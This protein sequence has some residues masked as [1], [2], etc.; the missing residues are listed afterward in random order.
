MKTETKAE[1]EIIR[2]AMSII[3]SKMT[4]KRMK[5]LREVQAPMM[6]S[7]IKPRKLNRAAVLDIR[8]NCVDYRSACALAA[9]YKVNP[10]TVI[11][12]KKGKYHANVK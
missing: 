11:S 6:R 2:K 12:T 8:A 9:K 10:T 7:F 3:G 1:K 4:R 5:H